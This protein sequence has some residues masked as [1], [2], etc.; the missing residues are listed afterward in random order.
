MGR[1][2]AI[3]S[4]AAGFCQAK[5]MTAQGAECFRQAGS[6]YEIGVKPLKPE[7]EPDGRLLFLLRRLPPNPP[8]MIDIVL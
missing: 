4:A 6:G 3:C 2:T 1:D 8:G 5:I 7:R